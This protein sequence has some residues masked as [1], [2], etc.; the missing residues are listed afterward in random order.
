MHLR[1][2]AS[3]DGTGEATECLV[4][5]RMRDPRRVLGAAGILVAR[6]RALERLGGLVGMSGPPRGGP[7][8]FEIVGREPAVLVG[9]SQRVHRVG[10]RVP[11]DGV[12]ATFKRRCHQMER[13]AYLGRGVRAT[14]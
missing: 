11:P 3:A 6:E 1:H 12:P 10:P 7:Q 4:G 9:R 13:T 2:P 8:Q 5:E 14:G